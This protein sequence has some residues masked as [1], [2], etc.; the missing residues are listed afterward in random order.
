ML[1]KFTWKVFWS[2]TFVCWEFLNHCFNFSTCDL[3][4]HIFYFSWFSLGKLYFSRNFPFLLSC[5]FLFVYSCLLFFLLLCICV[6]S[7]VTSFIFQFYWFD[8]SFFPDE[9]KDL[10][11]LFTF[12][13]NQLLV[14]LFFLLFFLSILL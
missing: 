1:I 13:K 11:T 7:A 10:P 9:T 5:L 3:F 6:T 8:P 14:S 2:W 4:V 12:S